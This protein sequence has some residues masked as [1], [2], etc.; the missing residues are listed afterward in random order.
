MPSEQRARLTAELQEHQREMTR[1]TSLLG[2]KPEKEKV[3]LLAQVCK[4]RI[5]AALVASQLQELVPA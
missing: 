4:H 1:I 3:Y 2:G 5:S